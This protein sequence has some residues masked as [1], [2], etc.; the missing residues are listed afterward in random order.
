[1]LNK[2]NLP[3]EYKKLP[4]YFDAH[5]VSESTDAQNQIIEA[6]LKKHGVQ[7][8]LDMTCGT[9]CQVFYLAK[10]GYTVTGSD[11]S[12]PLLNIARSKAKQKGVAVTFM[13]GDMRTLKVGKFDAVITIFNAV[14]HV[15]KAGFEK[16]MRNIHKNLKKGG[17]YI[18]DI[19]NL[20]AMTDAVV[21]GLAMDL[22]RVINNTTLHNKQH[23]TLNRANGR[24]TS[25]DILT[26][27]NAENRTKVYRNAF[28]LQIY[29]AP[30]LC[31]M[32]ARQGFET[33]GQFSMDG[34]AFVPDQTL[35]ILTVA[36]K[37]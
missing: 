8:V 15:S 31:E 36:R 18:F 10:R 1:M 28:T 35:N 13:H 12:A 32:L 26:I 25:H 5:N 2:F 19:F 11:F 4:Q 34:G 30:E 33:L 37:I 27:K 29:T 9:G 21:A 6:L 23:S 7:S 16:A 22:H 20:E 24:L 14:G 17:L 3:L